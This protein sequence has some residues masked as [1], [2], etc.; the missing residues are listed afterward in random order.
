MIGYIYGLICS[1]VGA[2]EDCKKRELNEY[3]WLS[4][5]WVG[6]LLHFNIVEFL[7]IL[8]ISLSTIYEKY[9]KFFYLGLVLLIVSIML[10]KSYFAISFLIIYILILILYYLNFMGGGDCK[11]LLG[12]SYLNGVIFTMTIFLNSI[13]FVIPLPILFFM[14]NFKNKAYKGLKFKN[15]I[16]LFISLK[17]DR[18]VRK[19]ETIVGK[20]N[21][22]IDLMPKIN[23]ENSKEFDDTPY[24]KDNSKNSGNNCIS[25]GQSKYFKYDDN[26]KYEKDNKYNKNYGKNNSKN[27]SENNGKDNNKSD[28]KYYENKNKI[29][30]ENIWVT[31][32]LPFLIF[33]TLSYILYY[34]YPYPVIFR[35]IKLIMGH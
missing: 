1:I 22:V 14:I 6:L 20:N 9:E 34:I 24:K 28:N 17:K 2:Y 4:M 16:L 32:Q 29:N 5:L 35:I 25:N 26:T 11:F 31:P 10:F 19:F 7:G 30:C 33:I 8:L 13:L 15:L 21:E 18:A 27:N 23:T 12:L 3:L